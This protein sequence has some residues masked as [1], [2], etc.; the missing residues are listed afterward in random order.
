MRDKSAER[1]LLL[2]VKKTKILVVDSNREDT[3]AFKINDEEIEEVDDFI[4]LGSTITNK[5]N[6]APEIRRRLVMAREAVSKWATSGGVEGSAWISSWGCYGPLSSPC[7]YMEVSH[8]L[9][10]RQMN[11]GWTPLR[12]GATEGSYKNTMDRK[13][14]QRMGLSQDRK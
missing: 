1:G 12:Y 13:E 7:S 10:K 6:S 14:N 11:G 3:S 2:N 8:G 4:Y 9:C 5:G